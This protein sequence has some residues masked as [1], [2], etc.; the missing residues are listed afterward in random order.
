MKGEGA[1]FRPAQNWR[2]QPLRERVDGV[3]TAVFEASTKLRSIQ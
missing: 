1:T 3:P 2:G